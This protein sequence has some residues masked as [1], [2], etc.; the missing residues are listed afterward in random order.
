MPFKNLAEIETREMMPGFLGRF[1]HTE[2]VT[3]AFWEIEAGGVLPEHAHPHE[4]VTM[5]LEGQ[6]TLTINEETRTLEPGI[7]A[8]IPSN[9]K[10]SG[11]ALT[12]CRAL[13]L[14]Q[15]VREDYR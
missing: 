14:F 11:K 1:I 4:Q 8:V 10:H 2:R 3:V 12:T 15:P 13:D 6:M 7:V 9:A 5:L